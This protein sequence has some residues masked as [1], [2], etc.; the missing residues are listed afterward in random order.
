M[1]FAPRLGRAGAT[2]LW[3]WCVAVIAST[4]MVQEHHI[5]DIASG[6]ALALLIRPQMVASGPVVPIM[7]M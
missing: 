6:I 4:W 7:A 2:A 1:F 5:A 3:A